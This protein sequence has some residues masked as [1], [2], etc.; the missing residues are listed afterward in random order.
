MLTHTSTNDRRRRRMGA[1]STGLWLSIACGGNSDPSG[2]EPGSTS[3]TC[4][5]FAECLNLPDVQTDC[6]EDLAEKRSEAAAVGCTAFFDAFLSCDAEHPGTCEPNVR[7]GLAAECE[8]AQD[9]I[10]DC[11]RDRSPPECSYST[12][13]CLNPPCLMN[14][15]NIDCPD[16][17]AECSGTPGQ[18][19]SCVCTTGAATGRQFTSTNCAIDAQAQVCR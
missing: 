4:A 3:Q 16:F 10:N 19:V 6:E 15:C 5:R 13:P 17:S 2:P 11:I 8:R 7:Y 12:A 18:P 9:A 1:L 14:I